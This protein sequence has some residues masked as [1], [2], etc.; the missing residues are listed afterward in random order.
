MREGR[1]EDEGGERGRG[2]RRG[3][4]EGREGKMRERRER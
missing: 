4:D 2:E 1:E 3:E